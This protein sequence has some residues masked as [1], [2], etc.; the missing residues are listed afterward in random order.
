MQALIESKHMSG[1]QRLYAKLSHHVPT[2]IDVPLASLSRWKIGGLGDLVIRPTTSEQA[3]AALKILYVENVDYVVVGEGSNILFDD[4]GLRIPMLVISNALG[5]F[6]YLGDGR[7]RV[8]A[9]HW[10][11]SFVR[12]LI[13]LGLTGAEHAIGIPGTLGGLIVMNGGSQRRGIGEQLVSVKVL[14]KMGQIVTMSRDECDFSYRHSALQNSGLVVAEAE[15]QY[16]AGQA[17]EM[18]RRAVATLIERKNKFP[19][20]LPNC[21]SVFV[22]NPKM[23]ETVG[24]PGHAI[25]A[26]GLK[27]HRIG[28]AQISELHAN[29]IV[30]LGHARATDVL[31]LIHL[32]RDKVHELTGF[33]LSCEV[34]HMLPNGKLQ[35]AHLQH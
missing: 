32:M 13:S 16:E 18:R 24:P 26:A 28:N 6:D 29:F 21:G 4:A 19:R 11:P 3:A 7:V 2:E 12:K 25:E 22:S 33:W 10:V 5:G 8:G 15:F 17:F 27:G 34:R 20:Y 9:G 30:N 1:R 31:A 23:Y 35:P 14:N